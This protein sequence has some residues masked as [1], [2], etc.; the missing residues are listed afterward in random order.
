MPDYNDMQAGNVDT[1]TPEQIRELLR[2]DPET[3]EFVWIKTCGAAKAGRIAGNLNKS[4]GYR[5]IRIKT[6]LYFAHRLAWIYMT[7]SW[8][9]SHVDHIDCD[10]SNNKWPNLRLASHHQ[11]LQNRG[12][13]RANTSGF[14][15]VW[16][17]GNSWKASIK[18][19]YKAYHLGTFDSPQKAHAAYCAAAH[20]LHGEFANGGL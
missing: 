18:S 6:K 10:G 7:G 20:K 4:L 12:K 16:K 17:V 3:G 13:T 14:K 8:P 2:Y 1:A 11:N 15:G 19:K 9:P 5:Q